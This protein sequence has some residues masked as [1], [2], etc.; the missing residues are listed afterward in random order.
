MQKFVHAYVHACMHTYIH[1]N[2]TYIT[3]THTH[4]HTWQ[5]IYCLFNGL[6]VILVGILTTSLI[7]VQE[8][9]HLSEQYLTDV[10]RR[11]DQDQ[12][13]ALDLDQAQTAL[14]ELGLDKEQ[15]S[16]CLMKLDA[17]HNGQV[18]RSEWMRV[19]DILSFA[20]QGSKSLAQ[21]HNHLTGWMLRRALKRDK[22][23]LHEAE[24]A[25][26]TVKRDLTL[27]TS[28]RHADIAWNLMGYLKVAG[29][30]SELAHTRM[31]LSYSQ[32]ERARMDYAVEGER[33]AL[34][35]KMKIIARAVLG[36]HEVS[37]HGS[38]RGTGVT[39]APRIGPRRLG[40]LPVKGLA[41]TLS[42]SFSD[43]DGDMGVIG[44]RQKSLILEEEASRQAKELEQMYNCLFKVLCGASK[45]RQVPATY[46]VLPQVPNL[47][48][49]YEWSAAQVG[50]FLTRMRGDLCEK[51]RFREH[52]H[53]L[54]EQS[55][56]GPGLA[57][58][59][60]SKADKCLVPLGDQEHLVR[61]ICILSRLFQQACAFRHMLKVTVVRAE[62]LPKMDIAGSLDAYVVLR[63]E[64]PTSGIVQSHTTS[65]VED[66]FNPEVRLCLY[67]YL[68]ACLLS[69]MHLH[70]YIHPCVHAC[71]HAYIH[72]RICINVCTST[73]TY[74]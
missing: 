32:A 56:D 38:F 13:D 41:G 35:E 71:T 60:A 39:T 50:E 68:H 30:W 69:C 36:Q 73:C 31:L 14:I 5:Y 26:Q 18:T 47:L 6:L 58:F 4:T 70:A 74:A 20:R 8:Q 17:D 49:L 61:G 34:L 55:I 19:R 15:A 37:K 62:H 9:D 45:R 33:R 65:I 25:K 1:A 59:S 24:W 7:L 64:D 23:Q 28:K 21:H 72:V 12:T 42:G 40:A 22:D 11:F 67:M 29:C 44:T 66:C 27:L 46:V 52:A 54:V 51:A 16:K 57:S 53:K 10:F 63:L 43:H 3:Y 2:I 48:D